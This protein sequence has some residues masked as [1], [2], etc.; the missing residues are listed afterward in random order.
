M[1]IKL[2]PISEEFIPVYQ[3]SQSAGA[4]LKAHISTSVTIKPMQSALIPTGLYTE[5]SPDYHIE[6]RSRSG[7][8]L[9]N[10]I[11]VLNSPGTIDA[12]YRGEIGVI[13]MNFGQNDFVVNRGDRIAQMVVV[14]SYVATFT[15]DKINKTSRDIQGFGSTGMK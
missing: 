12:D 6:I 7:L 2:S 4:D 5:F 1:Q 8:A 15:I 3:S 11:A 13:L 10:Q 14:R 9:K